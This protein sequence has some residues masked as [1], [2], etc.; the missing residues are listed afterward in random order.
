MT[1]LK[2]ANATLTYL[3]KNIPDIILLDLVLPDKSGL[4][5]L[6][7]VYE[8]KLKCLVI[9]TENA[10]N[11][12]VK[13]MHYSAFDFIE[14]PCKANRLIVTLRNALHQLRLFKQVEFSKVGKHKLEQ[15]DVRLICA[16]NRNLLAEV[17]AGRFR[18]DLYYRINTIEIK[19]PSLRERGQDILLL[20]KFFMQKFAEEEQKYFHGFSAEAKKALLCYD[21]PGNVR[22]LKNTIHN[23]VVLNKGKVITAK[24]LSTEAQVFRYF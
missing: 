7:L 6:K 8:Q 1:H 3:K 13:A 4:D 11:L 10:V 14:K 22:Q 5:I 2:T 18:E 17:K 16:T 24:M 12:V 20:A 21:W 9:T 23:L 19:L 15:V